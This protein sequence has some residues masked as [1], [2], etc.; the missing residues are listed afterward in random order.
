[1][2]V[3]NR[4][5]CVLLLCWAFSRV[6][7]REECSLSSCLSGRVDLLWFATGLEFAWVKY[8]QKNNNQ[9]VINSVR[10]HGLSY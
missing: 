2:K 6:V 7:F 10:I 8:L 3:G 4:A 5:R 1:M 9:L